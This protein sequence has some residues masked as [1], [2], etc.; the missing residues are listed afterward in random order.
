MGRAARETRVLGK[1]WEDWAERR[2]KASL[3]FLSLLP[4]HRNCCASPARVRINN[5]GRL[6]TSQKLIELR[7]NRGPAA[8]HDKIRVAIG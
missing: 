4:F 1:G 6:K 2:K 8:S 3:S 5:N 7:K